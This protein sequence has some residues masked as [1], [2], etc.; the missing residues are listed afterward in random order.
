MS[1]APAKR[2]TRP[3]RRPLFQVASWL[4]SVSRRQTIPGA[5]EIR[6]RFARFI[7]LLPEICERNGLDREPLQ[8]SDYVTLVQEWM[9]P[10]P[11]SGRR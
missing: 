5:R 1:G 6:Q 9:R 4:R 8:F 2:R 11:D 7:A 3:K 10:R